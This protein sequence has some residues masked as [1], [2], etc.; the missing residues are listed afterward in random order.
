MIFFSCPPPLSMDFQEIFC[1]LLGCFRLQLKGLTFIQ[2]YTWP[3]LLERNLGWIDIGWRC[4]YSSLSLKKYRYVRY[5]EAKLEKKNTFSL[6]FI[7]LILSLASLLCKES[8]ARSCS[9]ELNFFAKL[10]LI[11]LSSD[12]WLDWA[13]L[14]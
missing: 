14:A 4:H 8:P 9:L 13:D 2:F 10:R 6:V 11:L 7:A 5:V 3:F 12:F 1:S